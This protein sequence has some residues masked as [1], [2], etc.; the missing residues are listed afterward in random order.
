M[1]INIC[2]VDTSYLIEI[3]GVDGKSIP[4]VR[5]KVV[6]IFKNAQ[7]SG[8]R[9]FVPLPCLFELGNHIGTVKHG[10]RRRQLA[11]W[12]LKTVESAI[13]GDGLFKIT[14]TGAPQDILDELIKTFDSFVSTQRI[15]LV[16][17]FVIIEARR[18]KRD[19]K[20]YK[21][22]VHIWT[23]DL[24]LKKNEPDKEHSAYL[25]N[26]DGTPHSYS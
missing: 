16:D 11:D 22:L 13:H 7:R 19:L 21:A 6:E 26:D 5:K 20:A 1:S 24:I 23:R 25:W 4:H 14:P 8:H 18:L 9:F 2:V 15:G 12:L 17:T 10:D 3:A